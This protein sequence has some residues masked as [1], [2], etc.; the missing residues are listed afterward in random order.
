MRCC[1]RPGQVVDLRYGDPPLQLVRCTVC[2]RREWLLGQE[3]VPTET[4]LAVLASAYQAGPR[5]AQAVRVRAAASTAARGA[6]RAARAQEAAAAEDRSAQDRVR[7]AGL[8]QGWAVLG[9]P[10]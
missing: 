7:L 8:L 3:A 5:A 10:A 2:T 6:A 4:A 1:G 9:P